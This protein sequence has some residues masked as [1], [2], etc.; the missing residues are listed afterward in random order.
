MVTAGPTRVKAGST[1]PLKWSI[2]GSG[3]NAGIVASARFLTGGASYTM[4]KSG[5]HWHLD[6]QTPKTWALV[7]RLMRLT[8][9]FNRILRL[10]GATVQS[11]AFTD[12]GLVIG[13]RRRRRRLIC[14]CGTSTMARY[15]TSRR[16][17]R[18]LDLGACQVW[19][20][21]DI[22]RIDCRC[23]SRVRTEQVPW[24]RRHQ[25]QDP[26]HPTTR[27]RL[28]QPRR[29]HRS[30]LPLPRRSH[31]RSAHGNL[32]SRTYVRSSAVGRS[33]PYRSASALPIAARWA[34][35]PGGPVTSSHS[36]SPASSPAS[37]YSS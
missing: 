30:H 12:R 28:P 7:D 29:P 35:T 5:P 21:A 18:H 3:V 2:S 11:A 10:T 14:P 23:C 36:I 24:A 31:P 20:E 8:T 37:V 32:S 9:A 25:R 1:V 33:Q 13:L 26:A 4:V 17:W 15:D 6:V 22:H 27:L 34:R 19:L 16:R